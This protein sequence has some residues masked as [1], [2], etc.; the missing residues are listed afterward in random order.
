MKSGIQKINKY[1][2]IFFI[3]TKDVMPHVRTSATHDGGM[4]HHTRNIFPYY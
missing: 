3:V 1:L 2:Q 4:E